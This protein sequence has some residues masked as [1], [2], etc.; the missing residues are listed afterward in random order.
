MVSENSIVHIVKTRTSSSPP[1]LSVDLGLVRLDLFFSLAARAI[2]DSSVLSPFS[3]VVCDMSSGDLSLALGASFDLGFLNITDEFAE[4]RQ[5]RQANIWIL[6]TLCTFV[7]STARPRPRPRPVAK[8]KVASST[9]VN[10]NITPSPV[11]PSSSTSAAQNSIAGKKLDDED[12][13]FLRNRGR[14]SQCW[15]KL[16]AMAKGVSAL[17]SHHTNLIL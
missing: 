16:R 7:M 6:P 8:P 11:Q 14:T 13:I 17:I 5:L 1:K 3:D 12:A 4:E 9:T 2:G 15:N 10:S